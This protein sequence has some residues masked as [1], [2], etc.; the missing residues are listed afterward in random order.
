VFLHS[1]E[2]YAEIAEA[3]KI[4]SD[5][6]TLPDII[7]SND[8]KSDPSIPMIRVTSAGENLAALLKNEGAL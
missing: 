6:E 7:A 3:E 2:I 5:L 8:L 4:P 1:A